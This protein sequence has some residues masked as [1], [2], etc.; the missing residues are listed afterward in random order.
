MR[1]FMMVLLAVLPLVI[2]TVHADEAKE[3][4]DIRAAMSSLSEAF[5][6]EDVGAIKA[7]MTP[8]HVAIGPTYDGPLSIDEQIAV[9]PRI[10]LTEW[11]PTEPAITLLAE[12]V[13]MSNFALSIVGTIDGKPL[14]SRAYVTEIWLKRNGGWR[15]HVYQ[16]TA[17]GAR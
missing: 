17:I 11:V 14:H 12:N 2:S 6:S 15:Q 3:I 9:F 7:L 5:I 1:R 10:A 4:A 8:D 13:A 16:E